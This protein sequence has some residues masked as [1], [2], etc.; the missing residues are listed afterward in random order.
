MYHSRGNMTLIE[1]TNLKFASTM[2]F[3]ALLIFASPIDIFLLIS[4]ISATESWIIFSSFESLFCNLTISSIFSFTAFAQGFFDLLIFSDQAGFASFPRKDGEV[5]A[6]G[7]L[8][9]ISP[10][11]VMLFGVCGI[12][13]VITRTNDFLPLARNI[14]SFIASYL[15]A[16]NLSKRGLQNMI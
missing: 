16:F 7:W 4:F 12:A 14:A 9:L 5:I 6:W 8:L 13:P 11:W 3:F 2:S 1:I 15:I 10:L